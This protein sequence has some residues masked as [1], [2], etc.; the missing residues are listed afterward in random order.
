MTVSTGAVNGM[1]RELDEAGRR[2]DDLKWDDFLSENGLGTMAESTCSSEASGARTAA[3]LGDLLRKI[4][5]ELELT[6][7]IPEEYVLAPITATR[8]IAEADLAPWTVTRDADGKI[9][10][11]TS[12]LKDERDPNLGQVRTRL[13]QELEKSSTYSPAE[14]VAILGGMRKLEDE[15]RNTPNQTLKDFPCTLTARYEHVRSVLQASPS[16][17]P[18]ALKPPLNPSDRVLD[19]SGKFTEALTPAE[20]ANPTTILPE[21]NQRLRME[22]LR[23][24]EIWQTQITSN[25]ARQQGDSKEQE[26]TTHTLNGMRVETWVLSEKKGLFTLRSAFREDSPDAPTEARD[27][28][29]TSIMYSGIGRERVRESMRHMAQIEHR[30]R[31]GEMGTPSAATALEVSK[32]YRQLDRILND[33]TSD[34]STRTVLAQQLLKELADPSD[35]NQGEFSDSCRMTAAQVRLATRRPS[36]VATIVADGFVNRVV[37]FTAPDGERKSIRIDKRNNIPSSEAAGKYPR[38]ADHPDVRSLASQIYQVC[39][40][41]AL[42][43]QSDIIADH[44]RYAKKF[45]QVDPKKPKLVDRPID[46]LTFLQVKEENE[47]RQAK[48]NQEAKQSPHGEIQRQLQPGELPAHDGNGMYVFG[49]FKG[50]KPFLLTDGARADGETNLLLQ[51]GSAQRVLD[52]FDPGKHPNSVLAHTDMVQYTRTR[53]DGKRDNNGPVS[54][55]DAD[56][57]KNKVL[58]AKRTGNLP[59]IIASIDSSYKD[60]EGKRDVLNEMLFADNNHIIIIKDYIP[61]Q[62]SEQEYLVTDDFYGKAYDRRVLPRS[63]WSAYFEP[64]KKVKDAQGK[65]PPVFTPRSAK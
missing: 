23:K 44:L 28:L 48:L 16:L 42:G 24:P 52:L 5:P 37:N 61:A 53:P 25:Y 4:I 43:T 38:P 40:M 21:A 47:V 57:L 6:F 9:I 7:N 26:I 54:F 56:D 11:A 10:S 58:D 14:M 65:E 2:T 59:L 36:V 19:T 8:Q 33:R 29:I 13:L 49:S 1:K 51:A 64:W 31:M 62:G 46:Q 17:V 60:E 34:Q 32:V 41:S 39:V 12:K 50:G 15:L 35:I 45:H 63:E 18:Q 22:T 3:A 30:M 55:K 20:L 27:L